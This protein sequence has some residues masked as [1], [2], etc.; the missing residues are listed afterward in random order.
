MSLL[1]GKVL[2]TSLPLSVVQQAGEGD[3]LQ[4]TTQ[5]DQTI[6]PWF[7]QTRTNAVQWNHGTEI[8]TFYTYLSERVIAA[9]NSVKE[10]FS[11]LSNNYPV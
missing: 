2:L 3:D 6:Y 5:D 8:P 11:E 10:S 1:Y 7:D 9:S 4:L